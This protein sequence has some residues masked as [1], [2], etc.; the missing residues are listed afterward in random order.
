MS[1]L[2]LGWEWATVADV[3]G[4]GVFS[5][6]DW[7]ES[8]DQ[9][10]EGEVR[11][12]QLADIGEGQFRDRSDRHLTSVSAATLGC[13]YLEAGDVLVARMPEPLGRACR[14]PTLDGPSVTA[15]DVCIL[16]PT[17]VG[18]DPAWLMWTINAPQVRSQIA[19]LQSGTT[20]KRISRKNLAMVE[21]AVPPR[22]EQERIVAAIEEH[23][24]RLDAA[25]ASVRAVASKLPSLRLDMARRVLHG[26]EL[27]GESP[28]R[29]QVG[30]ELPAGWKWISL[31][32]LG[33]LARGRSSHRPRND[34]VLYGGPYPFIQ[35]GDVA[36]SGGVLSDHRQSYS[37]LGLAQSRVWP[38]G[39]VVIT[40]AANI[41]DS[42]VLRLDA[43]FPDSVVG[44]V[45]DS[46]L[47]RPEWVERF[48]RVEKE[49]LER[50]APATAQK[51]INLQTL[52]SVLVPVP[53]L[54]E[55]DRLLAILQS[56]DELTAR[57]RDAAAA[58]QLKG[59][60]LR[61]VTLASAFSGQ[62]VPQDPNDE[63]ASVLFGR[64]RTERAVTTP[65]KRTRKAK[66]S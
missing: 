47:V 6:G 37:E 17:P 22:A 39:T 42:A 51:N 30:H 36:A 54:V 7:V 15:V 66:A 24:S 40:I 4:A 31:Q 28:K 63:P 16:R 13:T 45:P 53:P 52:R 10:P 50:F 46:E 62:L 48:I 18:V 12:L 11:L 59:R 19:A 34:P 14:V 20:R 25:S 27:A 1:D 5:D 43:C 57:L 23:L 26:F 33:E 2:P 61:R 41:A 3:I 56:W 65:A 38:R 35:T 44:L 29:T 9:D 58:A 64:I 21:M 60:Q 32:N 49:R 8:K 55:Q